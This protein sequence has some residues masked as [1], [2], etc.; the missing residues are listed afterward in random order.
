MKDW[1]WY[2]HALL[3]LIIFGLFYFVYYQPKNQELKNLRE[4]R[5]KTEKQVAELRI[6]KK[7][8]DKIEDKL[9]TMNATLAK[10]EAIIPQKKEISDILRKIQQLAYDSRLNI[11]KFVPQGVVEQ[12][13]YMEWPISV[14][15]TGDYHNLGLFFDSL[16][17]FSRLFTI[18]NFSIKSLREQTESSTIS[19]N[20]T[21]KTYIF[22]ESTSQQKENND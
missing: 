20:W 18:E 21:A 2:G 22:P 6:K 13:F 10:L 16:S 3:V 14:E 5:I 19:A 7:E 9:K 17:N 1:P 12:E 4:E 11:N 15:I 8:L